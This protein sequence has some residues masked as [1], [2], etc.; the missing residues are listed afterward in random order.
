MGIANKIKLDSFDSLF[1]SNVD[2][3][4]ELNISELHTFENHPFKVKDDENMNDLVESIK[5]NGVLNPII[6]RN[7][8]DGNGYEI[9]S[10]HR[11]KRASEI[12]GTTTIPAIIKEIDD[13]NAKIMMVDSNIYREEILPS[14]RAFSYKMKQEALK[15]QGCVG[16]NTNEEIGKELGDSARQVQRYVRLTHLIP[17]L[18]EYVDNGNI[19]LIPAVD[20]SYIDEKGQELLYQYT[21]DN[22]VY[23]NLQAAKKLKE[24]FKLNNTLTVEIIDE[25]LKKKTL[26][27][28]HTFKLSDDI[29]NKYFSDMDKKSIEK[30]VEKIISNYFSK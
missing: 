5:N 29:V 30:E 20:L 19:A 27:K 21:D 13:D 23:P 24:H 10:G 17:E 2:N 6:V 15:H 7:C 14:E 16:I 26:K 1:G 8:S 3:I 4:T 11:R 12:A 22:C 18:L 9:I 25:I 28:E